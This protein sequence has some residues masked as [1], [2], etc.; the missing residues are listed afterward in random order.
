[1]SG[2]VTPITPPGI[3]PVPP[4]AVVATTSSTPVDSSLKV[5]THN[6]I[7]YILNCL[8]YVSTSKIALATV[9]NFTTLNEDLFYVKKLQNEV[10]DLTSS[11]SGPGGDVTDTSIEN[12]S[13][14]IARLEDKFKDNTTE[15]LRIANIYHAKL[16]MAMF[17]VDASGLEPVELPA[18]DIPEKDKVSIL[19]QILAEEGIN[20]D[21]ED[22]EEI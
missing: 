20:L 4:P 21:S 9:A 3:S 17:P 22:E 2:T 8:L 5:L 10:R 12:L 1:M 16:E 15:G 14:L 6:H 19:K 7:F 13:D 11:S 18:V